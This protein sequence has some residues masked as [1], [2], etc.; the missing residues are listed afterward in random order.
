MPDREKN[1][2][3]L[4]PVVYCIVPRDLAP[5][6]HEL[7]LRHFRHDPFVEVVVERRGGDRRAPGERR[8]T[9]GAARPEDRR[10][11]RAVTGRRVSDRRAPAVE[12]RGPALP[13]RARAHRE[14]L[15]FVEQLEPAGSQAEDQAAIHLVNRFQAGDREAFAEIYTRYY[16]R[17]YAYLRVVVRS[18]SEAEDCTQQTFVRAFEA[19][20]RYQHRGHPF[21]AWLF[22][23]ARNEGLGQLQR[24]SRSEV[25]DPQQPGPLNRSADAGHS[26]LDV[27]EWISDRELLLFFERLPLVQR[28]ALALR[29][30]FDLSSAQVAQVLDRSPDDVRQ[31]QSRA[32]AALRSRLAAVGRGARTRERIRMRSPL[33]KS[34]VARGRRFA[35]RGGVRRP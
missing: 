5:W 8:K 27:L 34:R 10:R 33:R 19:L 31:L 1:A 3:V 30:L 20:P 28:Q 23:I 24:G 17:V 13:R 29:Y 6:L 15:V 32:L 35:L 9:D 4:R 16:A 26:P 12:V 2:P 18:E 25:V 7:L 14:R 21:A 11:V 22:R